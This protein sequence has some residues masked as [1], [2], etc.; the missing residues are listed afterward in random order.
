MISYYSLT[1]NI[2]DHLIADEDINTVVIGNADNIDTN[3][4]TLFPLAHI[5]VGSGTPK[6]GTV[7]YSV[8]VTTMDIIDIK[9]DDP[10]FDWK[11]QDNKQYI[12]NTMF[13]VL[14]NLD[15]SLDR[16]DLQELGWELLG[17]AVA[18]PFE[19][20][21]ENL[22]TGWSMVFTLSIPNTKQNC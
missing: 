22:L 7:N 12:L 21:Y 20:Q 5:L 19:D 16:G 3:K 13:S 4:Q 15:K 18:T 14:E 2:Y 8:T 17:D 9:K 11:G 6:G 1:K 10:D